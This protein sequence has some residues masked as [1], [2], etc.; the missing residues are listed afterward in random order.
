MT[1]DLGMP[2][3][4]N[5]MNAAV[6][7]LSISGRLMRDAIRHSPLVERITAALSKLSIRDEVP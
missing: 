2:L 6:A 1:N 7:R 5:S 3:P 4:H